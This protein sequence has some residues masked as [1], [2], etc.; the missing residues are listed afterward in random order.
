MFARR[1]RLAA[2]INQAFNHVRRGHAAS[3][4]T[5]ISDNTVSNSD[6]SG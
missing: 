2:N 1:Q 3:D 4:R 6:T 5:V